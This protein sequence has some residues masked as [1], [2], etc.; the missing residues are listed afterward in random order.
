MKQ[1][2][3]RRKFFL[4]S[5]LLSSAVVLGSCDPAEEAL[6]EEAINDP[7]VPYVYS[8]QE[9]EDPQE[10]A[11]SESQVPRRVLGKTG[12]EVSVLGL[13]CGSPFLDTDVLSDNDR[14]SI[15]LRA[16]E[17]GINFLD[18]AEFYKSGRGLEMIGAMGPEWRKKMVIMT[19]LDK[20]TRAEAELELEETFEHLN[21]DYVDILLVHLLKEE[22]DD[23]NL[24]GIAKEVWPLMLEA[25]QAGRVGHLGFSVMRDKH[26]GINFIHRFG[27]D[28]EVVFTPMGPDD[29]T[30]A[31]EDLI[32]LARENNIGLVGMKVF[33]D[34]T[35]GKLDFP[36]TPEE[37][38]H[39][40]CSIDGMA[41]FMVGH[42]SVSELE[43]NAALTIAAA[44][45]TSTRLKSAVVG[46]EELKKRLRNWSGPEYHDYM[47]KDYRDD[48]YPYRRS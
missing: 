42:Q 27:E 8:G 44:S 16:P 14:V 12:L 5:A 30:D 11:T 31:E 38:V 15:F 34:W 7:R 3:S 20:R 26:L 36:T 9:D 19:K 40:V 24:D 35:K 21:T 13:G 28:V 33:K 32:P 37:I 46:R 10:P 39:S 25:K 48:G 6:Q 47:K 17:L 41:S 2:I 1:K 45:P 43:E 29:I 4:D 23:V 18:S 22:E